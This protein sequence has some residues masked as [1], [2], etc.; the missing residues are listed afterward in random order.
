VD[1]YVVYQVKDDWQESTPRNELEVRDLHATTPQAYADMW[2]Y[3]FDTDLVHRVTAWNRPADEPLLHLLREPRRLRLR[4]QDGLWV[5]AVDAAAALGGRRYAVEGRL[6]I[7]VRDAF[8]PWNEGT[9]EL[10]GG[11][12]GAECRPTGAE[13]DLVCTAND[14][15]AAYLGGSSFRQLHRAGRVA[16]ERPGALAR[17]D[18]MFGSDPA[19]WCS[20]MF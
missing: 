19:P 20:F 13:P 12:E 16:E 11:P 9:F 2:R 15:G 18:A 14:L 1:A 6:A 7:G 3:V 17:A 5:R 4:V 8:C 10:E